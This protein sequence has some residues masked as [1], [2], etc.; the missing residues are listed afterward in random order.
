MR[1]TKKE[2]EYLADKVFWDLQYTEID[3]WTIDLHPEAKYGIK[4]ANRFYKKLYYKLK[5]RRKR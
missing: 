1:L 5:G 3:M 4:E 2:R